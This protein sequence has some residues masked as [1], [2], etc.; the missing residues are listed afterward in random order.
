M[1]ALLFLVLLGTSTFANAFNGVERGRL[2]AQNKRASLEGKRFLCERGNLNKE[3]FK[4]LTP[5]IEVKDNE[6]AFDFHFLAFTCLKENSSYRYKVR[7]VRPSES[8]LV[9]TPKGIFGSVTNSATLFQEKRVPLAKSE[10]K[11]DNF[12]SNSELSKINKGKEVIKDVSVYMAE[13][14]N[15]SRG[16]YLFKVAFTQQDEKIVTKLVK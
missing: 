9:T 3:S 13:R 16:H 11:I 2:S 6:L 12:F 15:L 4:V 5:K 14:G 8:F 1:K 10:F 7:D